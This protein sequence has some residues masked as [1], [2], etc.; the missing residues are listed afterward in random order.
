MCLVRQ[1]NKRVSDASDFFQE[2]IWLR[3]FLLLLSETQSFNLITSQC[4]VQFLVLESKSQPQKDGKHLTS[5][6][7][8][9]FCTRKSI[10][11]FNLFFFRPWFLYG[12]LACPFPAPTLTALIEKECVCKSK[13]GGG[14]DNLLCSSRVTKLTIQLKNPS[15]APDGTILEPCI[16][17]WRVLFRLFNSAAALGGTF[18]WLNWL[19]IDDLIDFNLTFI[20]RESS[21]AF[22]HFHLRLLHFFL[23]MSEL[24]KP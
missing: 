24:P 19:P 2:N 21:L 6:A 5:P 4:L 7:N 9:F 22:I 17:E 16:Q 15:Y 13:R 10:F 23:R 8:S 14:H 18:H 1:Y 12:P 3:M 11:F 20:K